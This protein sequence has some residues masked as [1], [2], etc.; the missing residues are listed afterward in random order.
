MHSYCPSKN[1][2]ANQLC[3]PDLIPVDFSIILCYVENLG[4][5]AEICLE[6]YS[7]AQLFCFNYCLKFTSHL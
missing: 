7:L 3:S 6:F 1:R 2:F 5:H 4:L